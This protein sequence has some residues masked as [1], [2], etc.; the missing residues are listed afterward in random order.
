MKSD[1]T[2][3]DRANYLTYFRQTLLYCC[4]IAG[5]PLASG[6]TIPID[7]AV[8]YFSKTQLDSA[9]DPNLSKEIGRILGT[10]KEDNSYYMVAVRTKPGDVEIHEQFKDIAIIRSGHGL[11]KTGRR[12]VGQKVSGQEPSREWKGGVIQDAMIRKLSPGDFIVIPAMMG[13]QY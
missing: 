11:L 5:P 7:S 13:H 12:V 8:I 2:I 9:L 3:F 6:Q 1:L 10:S 4:C